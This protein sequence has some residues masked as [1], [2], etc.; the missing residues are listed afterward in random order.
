MVSTQATQPM[1]LYIMNFFF[2]KQAAPATN[3]TGESSSTESKGV[4]TES[5]SKG[6]LTESKG[7]KT[8]SE[9]TVEELVSELKSRGVFVEIKGSHAAASTNHEDG[10][11]ITT[12]NDIR[13]NVYEVLKSIGK[14]MLYLIF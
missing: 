1:I 9:A 8:L 3:S 10:V 11:L 5:Q 6:G 7:G 12:P 4:S 14:D 2:K 13:Y